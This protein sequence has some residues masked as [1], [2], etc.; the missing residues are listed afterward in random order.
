MAGKYIEGTSQPLSGVY[1]L[2]QAAVEAVLMGDRGK[3]SYPF[4]SNWGPINE[5]T[6]IMNASEFD[7]V[8]NAGGTTLTAAKIYKHAFK[9]SPQEVLSYRMANL[10]AAKGIITLND[11]TTNKS[12]ELE[13]LYPSD[14]AFTIIVKDSLTE[15]NKTLEVIENNVKLMSI[16][17]SSMADL[18]NQLNN[19]DYIRVKSSGAN[20]PANNAGVTFVGGNNGDAVTAAE[21]AAYLDVIE[22]DKQANAFSLDGVT[23]NAI[24]TTTRTWV[25]RVREQG[26][27]ISFVQGGPLSWDANIAAANAQSIIC[28]HRAIVNVGNGL[29]GDSAADLAIFIAARVASIVLNR[30]ITDEKVDYVTVNKKLRPGERVVAKKSGTLVFVQDGNAI[31]IDEGVNTLTTPGADEVVDMGKIRVNNTLDQIAKDLE[32]FGVEYKKGRSNTDEARQTYASTVE[33]SYFK[34]LAT[35]EVITNVYSYD[36]DPNYHGDK[37]VFHPKIDEAFFVASIWPV[38]SMERI[39]Q[40]IGVHF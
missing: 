25:K 28:N 4:T 13:T 5:L 27:Y 35:R 10:A 16:D 1:T 6:T 20:F 39:Y 8:F 3:V 18:V 22:A 2:I 33:D 24:L 19:S 40:K 31:L 36:P 21:Y 12:L 9:G 23:D 26:F 30:S 17:A 32:A 7:D 14:R 34:P 38:D 29:E 11:D 15:G 37:A